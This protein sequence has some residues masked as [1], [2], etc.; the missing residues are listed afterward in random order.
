MAL[1]EMVDTELQEIADLV[2]A[3]FATDVAGLATIDDTTVSLGILSFHPEFKGAHDHAIT[4]ELADSPIEAAM[5][6]DPEVV[7]LSGEELG[8]NSGPLTSFVGI[9]VPDPLGGIEG[10]LWGGSL[11]SGR[12]IPRQ[13]ADL[14]EVLA[15]QLRRR[16]DTAEEQKQ[17]RDASLSVSESAG[18]LAT[19]LLRVEA[20]NRDLEAFAYVAS[21]E[22]ARPLTAIRGLSEVLNESLGNDDQ[23]D[24]DGARRALGQIEENARQ[25]QQQI[26]ALLSMSR[27]DTDT[28]DLVLVDLNEVVDD[29][30]DQLTPLISTTD[31]IV[32]VAALPSVT[33]EPAAL[34]AIMRNLVSNALVYRSSE[35]QP[36]IDITAEATEQTLTVSVVDNGL[37]VD[38]EDVPRLFQM[39]QRGNS[40]QPGT[41]IGLA[42]CARLI[43]RLDGEIGAEPLTPHGSRFW[44]SLPMND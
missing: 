34:R 11:G 21:H 32:T 14:L 33:G 25:L 5:Q 27:L 36:E 6:S 8:S 10:V 2:R 43:S 42:L 3:L 9:V 28:N 35:R 38:P 26:A 7:A 20:S 12:Q 24:R 41:G 22:L 4:V 44:F 40:G 29:V 17:L 13:Q 16:L 39:F 18:A 23:L 15:R 1:Q 19:N 31:A 30:I 37:G